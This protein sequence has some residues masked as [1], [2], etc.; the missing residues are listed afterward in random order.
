MSGV[1]PGATNIWTLSVGDLGSSD[2]RAVRPRPYNVDGLEPFELCM[3]AALREKSER[4]AQRWG[5]RPWQTSLQSIRGTRWSHNRFD[6]FGR[7]QGGT[8][9]SCPRRARLG[10]TLNAGA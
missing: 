9:T 2:P 10:Q 6:L 5:P 8:L 1:V 3:S 4:S 7:D